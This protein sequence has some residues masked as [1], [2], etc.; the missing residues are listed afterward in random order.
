MCVCVCVHRSNTIQTRQKSSSLFS[1]SSCALLAL[2]TAIVSPSS[3]TALPSVRG[4]GEVL[5]ALF[6]NVMT[7][8]MMMIIVLV[9]IKGGVSERVSSSWGEETSSLWFQGLEMKW[10]T[11]RMDVGLSPS[12]LCSSF[13]PSVYLCVCVFVC[14]CMSATRLLVAGC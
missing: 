12:S 7:T 6:E 5:S 4:H 8:I 14:V 10:R 3:F 13:F 1:F 2:L 9:K 11:Q